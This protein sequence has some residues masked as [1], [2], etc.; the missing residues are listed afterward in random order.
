MQMHNILLLT[1]L[2]SKLVTKIDLKHDF[3]IYSNRKTTQEKIYNSRVCKCSLTNGNSC[4]ISHGQIYLPKTIFGYMFS[5]LVKCSLCNV[6]LAQIS[7]VI[8]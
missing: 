2:N 7:I 3:H 5:M 4:S 6:E 8:I 1:L